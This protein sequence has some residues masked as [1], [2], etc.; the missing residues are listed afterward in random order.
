MNLKKIAFSKIT[1]TVI[2]AACLIFAVLQKL[3]RYFK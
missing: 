2:I 3:E 1:V